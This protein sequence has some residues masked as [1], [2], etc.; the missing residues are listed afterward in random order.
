M[1]LPIP[2]YINP[3]L[4]SESA[5]WHCA[6]PGVS[7]ALPASTFHS[8][9]YCAL[10]ASCASASGGAARPASCGCSAP[11]SHLRSTSVVS[12]ER[13][14]GLSRRS[15]SRPASTWSEKSRATPA[16]P[17]STSSRS[18]ASSGRL[19]STASGT[20]KTC[21]PASPSPAPRKALRAG[22]SGARSSRVAL[23]SSAHPATSVCSASTAHPSSGALLSASSGAGS[24]PSFNGAGSGAGGFA[25][26]CACKISF[27][28]PLR[29]TDACFS[30]AD[31]ASAST[32]VLAADDGEL[33]EAAAR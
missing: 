30:S 2:R 5:A 13:A 25:R 29:Y 8:F 11:S 32:G 16:A 21:V 17:A 14:T 1:S 22:R 6:S 28:A 27:S 33:P 31:S 10:S 19:A 15:A 12:S 26:P 18:A 4:A 7:F 20:R 9:P 24:S 3:A 23:T